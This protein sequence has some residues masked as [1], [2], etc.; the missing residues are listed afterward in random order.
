MYEYKFTIWENAWSATHSGILKPFIDAR[1]FD[2]HS[3]KLR[4]K[5]KE[6]KEVL[7]KGIPERRATTGWLVTD[8]ERYQQFDR[9]HFLLLLCLMSALGATV[10]GGLGGEYD[11]FYY[12][13]DF[14]DFVTFASTLADALYSQ[15]ETDVFTIQ[16]AM[17]TLKVKERAI[18]WLCVTLKE[19]GA[20]D[21]A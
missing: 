12:Y 19:F 4:R 2:V 7:R 17:L 3:F 21:W 11:T 16:E 8:A 18:R 6:L 14:D 20:G 15:F 13:V 9:E 5:A 1:I 10:F